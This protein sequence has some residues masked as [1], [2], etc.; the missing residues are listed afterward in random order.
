MCP[1]LQHLYGVN[2][3][4]MEQL[5]RVPIEQLDSILCIITLGSRLKIFLPLV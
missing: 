4:Q 2:T 5:D 1:N 3:E